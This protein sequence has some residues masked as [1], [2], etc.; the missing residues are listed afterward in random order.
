MKAN[1]R[2]YYDGPALVQ[3][4]TRGADVTRRRLQR[5]WAARHDGDRGDADRRRRQSGDVA[6]EANQALVRRSLTPSPSFIILFMP[7]SEC[8]RLR[9]EYFALVAKLNDAVEADEFA[10]VARVKE[11]REACQ[12]ALA[13]LHQAHPAR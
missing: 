11:I 12:E 5:Y 10:V 13:D 1:V 7:C 2:M 4:V 8:E 3:F 9:T 6:F